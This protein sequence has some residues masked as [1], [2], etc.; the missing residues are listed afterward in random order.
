[1]TDHQLSIIPDL[2]TSPNTFINYGG[3]LYKRY[4]NENNQYAYIDYSEK[5]KSIQ[6]QLSEGVTERRQHE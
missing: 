1:M 2:I 3:G 4:L 6:I 5:I